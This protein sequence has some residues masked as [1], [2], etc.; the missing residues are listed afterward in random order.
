MKRMSL[1]AGFAALAGGCVSYN[2][3]ERISIERSLPIERTLPDSGIERISI[4][5]PNGRVHVQ[6]GSERAIAIRATK[7]GLGRTQEEAQATAQAI[8]VVTGVEDGVASIEGVLPDSRAGRRSRIEFEIDVPGD[9]D[10]RVETGNGAIRVADIEAPVDLEVGNGGI[11][12]EAHVGPVRAHS[13]N[14]GIRAS[15]RLPEVDLE[16]GNGSIEADIKGPQV[17]GRMQV[18]NGGIDVIMEPSCST[19]VDARVGNGRVRCTLPLQEAT[20]DGKYVR[21]RL[22][23]GGRELRLETG[24]GGVTVRPRTAE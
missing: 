13:G 4:A 7:V 23:A 5:N 14:G 3:E 22:G 11:A 10:L 6:G 19:I 8:E 15:G 18:G 1:F 16:T 12:I 24:N 17:S 21:G 2:F 9:Q 20:V